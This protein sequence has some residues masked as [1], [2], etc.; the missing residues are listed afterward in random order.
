MKTNKFLHTLL[1]FVL[2]LPAC[3]AAQQETTT[4]EPEIPTA[5]NPIISATGKVVPQKTATL[6]LAASGLVAEVLVAEGNPVQAGEVL[7]RL[8]GAETAQAAIV[9]TQLE[10][11]AAQIALKDI[12]DLDYELLAAQARAQM[13]TAQK[14]LDDLQNPMLQQALAKQ[15]IAEAEKAVVA[16]MRQTFCG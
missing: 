11:T 14:A 2:L 12:H 8:D 7:L 3:S 6:S 1:I 16:G 4:P 10:L 9:A 15:A 5:F 13:D